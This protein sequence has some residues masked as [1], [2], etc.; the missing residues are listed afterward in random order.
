MLREFKPAL[1][2]LGKFLGIYIIGNVL[3]GFY[4]DAYQPKADPVTWWVTE[5]TSAGM[6][7]VGEETTYQQNPYKPSIAL[8]QEGDT[9]IN[10]FEGCNGLNVMIVFIAFVI[11]FG[12]GGKHIWWFIPAGLVIIHLANLFRVG[13]LYF[14]ARHYEQYFYY[15]HKYI[16]TAVLYLVIFIL[17]A[18]WVMKFNGKSKNSSGSTIA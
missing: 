12:G 14:V 13:L 17:W 8:M 4:I 15:V 11:A 3:Y 18:I 2:F 16:F 9:I 1:F 10:I 7:V 6:Q 5:Q